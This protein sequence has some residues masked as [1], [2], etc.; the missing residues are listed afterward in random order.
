MQPRRRQLL[1]LHSGRI[2]AGRATIP[3]RPGVGVVTTDVFELESATTTAT[4]PC[5]C[6]LPDNSLRQA[7]TSVPGGA[8][9]CD[10]VVACA[11]D[12]ARA[13]EVRFISTNFTRIIFC[14]YNTMIR[15]CWLTKSLSVDCVTGLRMW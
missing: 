1:I 3:A 12:W 6:K 5:E 8:D 13:T 4:G 2:H 11:Q 15:S 9:A 7:Y 10:P 14:T